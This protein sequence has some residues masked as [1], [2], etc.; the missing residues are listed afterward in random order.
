[1]TV[2]SEAA[3]PP[4]RLDFP[5]LPVQFVQA[6]EIQ[7]AY[8]EQG[9]GPATLLL[10]HGSLC[11]SLWW[12]RVMARLPRTIRALAVDLR[13][14]GDSDKADHGYYRAQYVADLRAFLD[15]LA[16]DRVYYAGHSLGGSVGLEFLL[17]HPERILAQV[18]IGNGTG[19]RPSFKSAARFERAQSIRADQSALRR[20]VAGGFG[21]PP[22]DELLDLLSQDAARSTMG[23]WRGFALGTEETGAPLHERVHAIEAPIVF[24]HGDRDRV[25]PRDWVLETYRLVPG[26]RLVTFPGCGH[27]VHVEAPDEIAA[28]IT[29]SM[30]ESLGRTPGPR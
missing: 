17:T 5:I 14:C 8:R 25:V 26:A 19:P 6:G 2:E 24:C 11:S 18:V 23:S 10:V 28:I 22:E 30:G 4:A 9:A 29:Q 12:G 16:I 21:V 20:F 15:A 7:M 1:M 13:G 3:P 27:N